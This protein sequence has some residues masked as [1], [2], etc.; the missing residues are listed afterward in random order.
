MI[1]SVSSSEPF[2]TIKSTQHGGN[3]VHSLTLNPTKMLANAFIS[4]RLDYC[5]AVLHDI[6][7]LLQW[8]QSVQKVAARLVTCT[9]RCEHITSVY[10]TKTILAASPTDCKLVCDDICRLH[11][12]A[13][14]TC[15]ISPTKTR[16][17][18]RSFAAAG[19]QVWN[20]LPASPRVVNNYEHFKRL[21]KSN[22]YLAEAVVPNDF[23]LWGAVY[24]H[25]SLL[26]LILLLL[27]TSILEDHLA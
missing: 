10:F 6:T 26:L 1:S 27:N 8:L 22:I 23:K 21:L 4:S 15:V 14:F 11:S 25:I 17:G 12:A 9:G 2:D 19:P 16:R 13:S 5:N 3:V 18:D 24:K 7:D 20:S